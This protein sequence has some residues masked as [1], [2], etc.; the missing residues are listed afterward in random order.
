MTV[1]I[2]GVI[3]PGGTLGTVY[4]TYSSGAIPANELALLTDYF[5]S[6]TGGSGPNPPTST[7]YTQI[8]TNMLSMYFSGEHFVSANIGGDPTKFYA[9]WYTPS[10]TDY[11]TYLSTHY[12]SYLCVTHQAVALFAS[13]RGQMSA[14]GPTIESRMSATGPKIAASEDILLY[15]RGDAQSGNTYALPIGT[16]VPGDDHVQLIGS[17]GVVAADQLLIVKGKDGGVVLSGAL[18][19]PTIR[20]MPYVESTHGV[21]CRGAMTPLGLVY[22][23]KTGIYAWSGGDTAVKL[24]T[25]IDGF[26]WNHASAADDIYSGNRGRM[27]WWNRFVAVPNNYLFNADLGS[28]WRLSGVS[29]TAYNVYCEDGQ[30]RMLAFPYK[31][32]SSQNVLYHIYDQ[33]ILAKSYSWQSQPLLET[34][35]RKTTFQ[36]VRMV[37]THKGS[38]AASI[39]VTLSG[40]DSTGAAVTPATITFSVPSN[41]ASVPQLLYKDITPNFQAE[42]VQVRI[43]ADSNNSAD[44]APKVHSIKFGTRDSARTPRTA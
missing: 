24:S 31:L 43:Q 27:A 33:A 13:V 15:S 23:S 37:V 25:Q 30:G 34:R 22:G 38:S 35:G 8:P 5:S 19:S 16:I 4:P 18:G 40:Y 41:T 9:S 10:S 11:N 36:E 6:G 20:R 21:V 39:I 12:V 3:T 14:G 44:P 32:S 42:Y 17:F 29:G 26:F 2:V 28:W 1:G 7:N